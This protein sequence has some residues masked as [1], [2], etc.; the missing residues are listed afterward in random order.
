VRLALLAPQPL[1][2]L[3]YLVALRAERLPPSFAPIL[4]LSALPLAA[5]VLGVARRWPAALIVV[6]VVELAW[7]VL[8]E[9][10]VGFAIAWQSG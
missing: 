3:A 10:M 8:A 1:L 5:V 2:S 9:A 4:V 7:A 6:A